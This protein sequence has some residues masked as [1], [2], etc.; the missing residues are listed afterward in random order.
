MARFVRICVRFLQILSR[1]ASLSLYHV[2][3]PFFLVQD[4][5]FGPLY[6]DFF[7]YSQKCMLQHWHNEGEEKKGPFI[8]IFS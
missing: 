3:I 7:A 1:N 5:P 2:D 4:V 8:F 6:L